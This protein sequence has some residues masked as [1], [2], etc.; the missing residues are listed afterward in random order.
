MPQIFTDNFNSYTDGDLT[1][2]GSWSGSAI[3]D[4]QGTTVQEGAKAIKAV[5]TVGGGQITKLG[6]AVGTGDLSIYMR[7][8]SMPD[9]EKFYVQILEGATMLMEVRFSDITASKKIEYLSSAVW[10]QVGSAWVANTW[11][12]INVEW[13]T[14]DNTFRVKVDNGSWTGWTGTEAAFTNADTVQLL[15]QNNVEAYFDNIGAVAATA[16][17]NV[18]FFGTNW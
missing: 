5:S 8:A 7:V 15:T 3:F 14:S 9:D 12:Q 18:V 17:N 2:Q 11:Y 1:T 6:T 4:V 16:E 13:R 10:T